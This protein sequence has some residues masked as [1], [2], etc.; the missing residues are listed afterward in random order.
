MQIDIR[1]AKD[2]LSEL[3]ERVLK[4]ENVVITKAGKPLIDLVPHAPSQ[5]RVPGG[6]EDQ[7]ELASDFNQTSEDVTSFFYKNLK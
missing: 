2:R 7:I 4:G 1:E 5:Q 6:F 3:V